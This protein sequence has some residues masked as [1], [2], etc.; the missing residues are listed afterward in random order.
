[1]VTNSLSATKL[2]D[3]FRLVI[4]ALDRLEVPNDVINET[5][6][7]TGYDALKTDDDL[8]SILNK[9]S[10]NVLCDRN[11][12]LTSIGV[13]VVSPKAS[14]QQKDALLDVTVWVDR[15]GSEE[16]F[17]FFL[18]P[19]IHPMP[20]QFGTMC[21][22]SAKVFN[23]VLTMLTYRRVARALT[24]GNIAGAESEIRRYVDEV[25][26]AIG[27]EPCSVPDARICIGNMAQKVAKYLATLGWWVETVV[28]DELLR[29]MD[30]PP[31]M[32]KLFMY[33]ADSFEVPGTFDDIKV[34]AVNVFRYASVFGNSFVGD[35][36]EIALSDGAKIVLRMRDDTGLEVWQAVPG[37]APHVLLRRYVPTAILMRNVAMVF[38]REAT[39]IVETVRKYARSGPLEEV[40][41]PLVVPLYV[42]AVSLSGF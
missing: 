27:Y 18:D 20:Y 41:R 42:K 34:A 6:A 11:A 19:A 38:E 22:R 1:M 33:Y 8:L 15:G 39:R 16:Y 12:V 32:A 9:R 31:R 36:V 17:R 30:M 24:S 29:I 7:A 21:V 13:T 5:N 3:I 10:G 2:E 40:L 4:E 25:V 26:Q 14:W 23:E 35:A 37:V 28:V